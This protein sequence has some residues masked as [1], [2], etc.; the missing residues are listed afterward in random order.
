MNSFDK[1]MAFPTK[2]TWGDSRAV[3]NDGIKF[4]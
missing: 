1:L 2:A 3:G 4:L